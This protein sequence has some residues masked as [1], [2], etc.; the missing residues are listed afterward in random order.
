MIPDFKQLFTHSFN[1]SIDTSDRFTNPMALQQSYL[2]IRN[3]I[4]NI[5]N[6]RLES[7]ALTSVI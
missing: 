6:I 4:L 7:E 1:K 5:K 2:R 3:Y